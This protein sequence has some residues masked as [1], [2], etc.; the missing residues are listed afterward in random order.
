MLYST[1]YWFARMQ[2]RQQKE[3]ADSEHEK[4]L[5]E[6]IALRAQINPHFFIN[7][8]EYFR[9]EIEDSHP[10]VSEGITAMTTFVNSSIVAT[11]DNGKIP[12]FDELRAMDSLITI[13]RKRFPGANI[14]YTNEVYEDI[15]I[16]PH[17]LVAPVENAFK[18]GIYTDAGSKLMI[19][20]EQT[21]EDLVFKVSNRKGHRLKDKSRGIGMRYI[22]SQLDKAYPGQYSLEIEDK[23]EQYSLS[24]TIQNIMK[25]ADHLL[26]H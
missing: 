7:T 12:L 13:F 18:H 10:E 22:K 23:E 24:L 21:E 15:P 26:H 1:G 11:D 6:N 20:I 9:V 14:D 4:L 25:N 3:K 16:V 8:M 17:V 5:L 2:L 19:H